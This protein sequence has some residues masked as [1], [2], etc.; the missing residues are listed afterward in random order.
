MYQTYN[1]NIMNGFIYTFTTS[2]GIIGSFR[3]QIS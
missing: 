1:V 2:L 3:N